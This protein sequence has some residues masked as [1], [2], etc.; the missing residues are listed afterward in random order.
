MRIPLVVLLAVALAGCAPGA[1]APALP[2]AS[3]VAE[4]FASDEEAVEAATQAYARYST[5]GD[6]VGLEGGV[7][8]ERLSAVAVGEFLAGDIDSFREFQLSGQRQ[9]GESTFRDVVLQQ[10][11]VG[12]ED[13]VSV[14]LCADIS[15]V[16]LVD[17]IGDS[18]LP[19]TRPDANYLAVSFDLGSDGVLRV[20]DVVRW[21][22]RTC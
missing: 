10:R 17:A 9:V 1:E 8:A 13:V 20:S 4:P 7:D 6:Q 2:S 22:D 14:Y 11:S 21:D 15:G 18:V 5:L 3:V 16:D 12:P 19:A